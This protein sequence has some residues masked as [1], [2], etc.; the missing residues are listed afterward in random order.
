MEFTSQT[1]ADGVV[2]RLFTTGDIPGALWSP[3]DATDDRP[4]ILLGHGGG[5][6]RLFPGVV[7]RARWYVNGGGF[8]VA[9][10]DLPGH[11][12][13][14]KTDQDVEFIARF[15]DRVAQGL[16]VSDELAEFHADLAARAVP[17]WQSTL[18]ALWTVDGVAAG[19]PVGYA[20]VSMGTAVG[21]PLVAAE[22]RITAAVFGLNGGGQLPELA[23][24]ITIPIEF[25]LQWDDEMIAREDVLALYDA[26]AS[27]EKSLH[28]NPGR[29]TEMPLYEVESSLRF[30]ARHLI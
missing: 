8:A 16:P 18:D 7:G 12:E 27:K 29:H 13:R 20:G 3:A 1:S 10:I 4:L 9:A 25:V 30:F 11:G 15:R 5:Q 19:G 14:P 24:R 17:E 6:H 26:F 22:P 23:A 28:V 2:Q 21:V